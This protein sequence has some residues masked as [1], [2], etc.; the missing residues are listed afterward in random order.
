MASKLETTPND[1]IATMLAETRVSGTGD[2]EL[3]SLR[4]QPRNQPKKTFQLH[5]FVR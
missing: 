4:L 3:N 5:S 1:V 2:E